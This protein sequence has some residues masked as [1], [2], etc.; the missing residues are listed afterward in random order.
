MFHG[1]ICSCGKNYIGETERNFETRCSEHKNPK[2]LS[3]PTR[4]LLN[5]EDH[6]FTWKILSLGPANSVHSTP[7]TF[8]KS[9]RKGSILTL[10]LEHRFLKK[11]YKILDQMS[12]NF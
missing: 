10:F 4:H 6:Y 12:V 3:E 5:H 7:Y 8:P 9:L 11:G 2:H 1:G